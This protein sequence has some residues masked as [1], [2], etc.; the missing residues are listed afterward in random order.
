MKK[1]IISMVCLLVLIFGLMPAASAAGFTDVP[2]DSWAVSYIDEAVELGVMGGYGD[3]QFGY[4]RYVSRAEFAAMLVR[5]FGWAL[6]EPET[7]SFDDNNDQTAWY[8]DEIETAVLN[9]AVTADSGTFRPDDYITREEMAVM[10]VRSL[11]FEPLAG[12][13][14]NVDMP[15]RRFVR[16]ALYCHGL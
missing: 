1:K 10:L 2:A 13:M 7:P 14:S 9:G 5:L 6:V 15:L 8:Y 3:G 11:G 4:G 16:R 12:T